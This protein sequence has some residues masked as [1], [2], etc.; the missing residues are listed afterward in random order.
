MASALQ[1]KQAAVCHLQHVLHLPLIVIGLRDPKRQ[2]SPTTYTESYSIAKK[3]Q[4]DICCLHIQNLPLSCSG[5]SC[6]TSH[7][8][9]AAPAAVV[10][11]P[12]GFMSVAHEPGHAAYT[13]MPRDTRQGCSASSCD[14]CMCI[15]SSSHPPWPLPWPS[16]ANSRPEEM[17]WTTSNRS[18]R[19]L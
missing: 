3:T 17:N 15:F 16:T 4:K 2:V 14:T 7:A 19:Q 13:V 6:V 5:C 9:V 11:L 8:G 10:C 1:L 12:C 18:P